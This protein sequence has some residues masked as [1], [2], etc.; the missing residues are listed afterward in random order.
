M[1]VP[2]KTNGIEDVQQ[3][4][5]NL[6]LDDQPVGELVRVLGQAIG[7]VVVVANMAGV[8]LAGDPVP[9]LKTQLAQLMS[10]GA[11]SS[12]F[13][14]QQPMQRLATQ[15]GL[16][17]TPLIIH[18]E[19][20][21]LLV[22]RASP[23]PEVKE[24]LT[25]SRHVITLALLKFQAAQDQVAQQR[26]ALLDDLLTGDQRSTRH[27]F[28]QARTLGWEL[29]SKPIAILLKFWPAQHHPLTQAKSRH[30]LEQF[31]HIIEQVLES[32]CPN[33]ILASSNNGFVILPHLTDS[34]TEAHAQVN[35]L[36][37]QLVA[38]IKA[39]K[40]KEGYALACGDFHPGP[41]GLRRSYQEAEQALDV[42]TRL[43]MRRP[44]RFEE[45]YLY[46][47]LER[48]G[49]DE[50]VRDWVQRTLGPLVEYDRRNKTDMLQTLESY[51]DSNQTLQ[52]A[53][54]ALHIHPNT[55]KYRLG[56]I[57]QILD[58]DPFKGENQLRFYLATKMARLLQS[59]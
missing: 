7:Q 22:T 56:R 31:H 6:L 49:R 53:A 34:I 20:I 48:S 52:E 51:F 9:R 44:I 24:I 41:D 11:L 23:A 2:H 17:F 37:D 43:K 16:D 59:G 18:H 38:A 1:T 25:Q 15:V 42:G 26:Q 8:V 40:I 57:A 13:Q 54:Y 47:L 29:E 28:D 10:Q 19:V 33:S 14:A 46:L 35:E 3:S 30:V 39:A 32:H 5:I 21:G 58:Q 12:E 45:I 27:L 4:L 50:D 55:L 36:L